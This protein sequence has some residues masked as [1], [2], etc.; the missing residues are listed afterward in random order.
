[1]NAAQA[2]AD[3]L[4]EI[5]RLMETFNRAA[6]KLQASHETIAR[7]QGELADRDRALARRSRLEELGRMA[8][9]LAHEIRN[10]LGGVRLYAALLRRDLEDDAAKALRLDRILGAVDSLEKLVGDML[11]FGRE[12]EPRLERRSLSLPVESAL[13]RAGLEPRGIAVLRQGAPAELDLDPE[14][15]SRAFLNVVL[16]ASEAM[17][18]AGTL[19]VDYAGRSVAFADTGPG[20][21]HALLPKLFQPFTTGKAKGTG[22][23]LAIA[24]RIVESHGGTIRAENLPAGGARFTVTL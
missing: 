20:I 6:E 15:L 17:G 7:L 22:L 3:D 4:R 19:R 11:D 24:Q 21:P 16:N 10:P 14:M 9:T 23:G 2:R 13:E 18:G 8:A 1:V 5:A 12:R